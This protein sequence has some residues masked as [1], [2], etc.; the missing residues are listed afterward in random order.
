MNRVL[1][2]ERVISTGEA[3]REGLEEAAADDPDVIFLAEGVEDPNAVYGTLKG[4]GQRIGSHRM[5]EMPLSENAL[6]G[7]AIGAAMAGKRPVI[8]F[9][10]VEFALLAMEQMV[11]NAAKAHYVSNGQHRVPLVMR[12]VVGRGWGQ[13]PAHSQSFETMFAS[14]PGLKVV[15]PVFAADAKGMMAAAVRDNNP[16]ISIESRW[17]HYLHG[18]VPEGLYVEAL[19]GPRRL[20]EGQA[21]TVVATSYMT[22]EAMRAADT[23]QQ[24]GVSVD[25][26]DLRLLRP[27]RLEAIRESVRRT[28]RL[29]TVDTGFRLYGAGAEIAADI[30]EHCFAALKAAP[31]RLGLPDHPTPSSRGLVVNYYP[32]ALRIVEALAGLLDLPAEVETNAR[33]ALIAARGDLPVDVPD[34]YFRGPF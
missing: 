33:Q 1:T 25:L 5:I 30:T 20:R 18:H 7:V 15:M 34:Q 28:G 10:R 4:I 24:Q 19:D 22:L 26:F 3:I 9:H 6:C 11:N 21:A 2:N 32:D 8:S 17:A 16:V 12:L 13:G 14:V 27:L 23:L 31:R 29:L